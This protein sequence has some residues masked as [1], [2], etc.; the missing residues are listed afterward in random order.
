MYDISFEVSRTFEEE[1]DATTCVP[2]FD[3]LFQALAEDPSKYEIKI[4]IL[5]GLNDKLNRDQVERFM[6]IMEA[7]LSM[8]ADYNIFK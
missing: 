4:A 1:L 2:V 5:E 7:T 6:M 3:T 8:P